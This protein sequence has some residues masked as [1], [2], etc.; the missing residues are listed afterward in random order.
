[1]LDDYYQSNE[2]KFTSRVVANKLK[3]LLDVRISRRQCCEHLS[4]IHG[5]IKPSMR[6]LIKYK[7]R[8]TRVEVSLLT[9]TTLKIKI[10]ILMLVLMHNLCDISPSFSMFAIFQKIHVRILKSLLRL[11][12]GFSSI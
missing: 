9:L 6:A 8:Q 2:T 12:T 11:L 7:C 3:T 1:M 4:R 5:M 10:G